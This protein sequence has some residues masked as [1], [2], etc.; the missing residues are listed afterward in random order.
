M[1]VMQTHEETSADLIASLGLVS[2]RKYPLKLYQITSKFRDEMKPRFGL[3]RA[4]QFIM[5]DL[6]SFDIDVERSKKTYAQMCDCYDKIFAKLAI[7]WVKVL[8]SSGTMGGDLSHEYHLPSA[9]GEDK[10]VQCGDCNYSANLE[11][12][13]NIIKT[14]A[15]ITSCPNCSSSN[16]KITNGIEV[17]HTFLLGEKYSKAL[18]S[19]YL[20]EDGKPKLLH[21]GSYGLGVSR[22]IAAA[23][24]I[25]SE[26]TAIKWPTLLAPYRTVIIGPKVYVIESDCSK[27]SVCFRLVVKKRQNWP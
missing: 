4:R 11:Y 26:E 18:N 22:I 21:M 2:F 19:K 27:Y 25:L 24:E 12:I 16:I 20:A 14:E 1:F 13:H 17:G 15:N 5:K 7:D 9:I 10:L 3:M 6:Y 8:G 23:V